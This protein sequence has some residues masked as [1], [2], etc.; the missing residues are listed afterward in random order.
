[1][2]SEPRDSDDPDAAQS[3]RAQRNQSRALQQEAMRLD[4]GD[5]MLDLSDVTE[6]L[7]EN[8]GLAERAMSGAAKALR[9]NRT[10]RALQ[11]M[12]EAI[13]ELQSLQDQL[14]DQANQ[15]M[16]GGPGG[17]PGVRFG[18]APSQ[19]RRAMGT[20]QGYDPLGRNNEY[21]QGTG[22]DVEVPSE[23]EVQRARGI[24]EELRRRSG[25]FDRPE[26]ELDYI[27]RLL[28]RF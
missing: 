20:N 13:E 18:L 7:P 23:S 6:E 4:L 15:G 12:G 28:D 24:L 10:A 2:M 21:G 14:Q 25:E 16:A 8:L 26:E 17:K 3:E 5:I 27:D 9:E 22:S 11:D 1:M 19:Q